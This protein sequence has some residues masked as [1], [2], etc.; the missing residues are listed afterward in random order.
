MAIKSNPFGSTVLT[1]DDAMAFQRQSGLLELQVGPDMID[2]VMKEFEAE[3]PGKKADEM[4][5]SEFADRMMKKMKASA[6]PTDAP[7]H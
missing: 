3:N 6:R 1:G 2:Q 4:S 5:P 7:R